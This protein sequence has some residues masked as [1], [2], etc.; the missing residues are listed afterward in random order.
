MY[1]GIPVVAKTWEG[2]TLVRT[3]ALPAA[4]VSLSGPVD[5]EMFHS[6]VAPRATVATTGGLASGDTAD[7]GFA[8]T[9]VGQY[10][11]V[12]VI[13]APSTSQTA[14]DA[15]T[16]A[17]NTLAGRAPTTTTDPA[18][19][20][21]PAEGEP[22]PPLEA[23]PSVYPD[24]VASINAPFCDKPTCSVSVS[25][26]NSG[27]GPGTAQVTT[28][29]IPGLGPTTETLGPIAPGGSANTSTY[30][31]PN[32]APTPAPGQTTTGSA[33]VLVQIYSQEIGGTKPDRYNSLVDK[34]GGPAKQPSLDRILAP[35]SQ[36]AKDVM[37]EAMNR[38]LDEEV[39]PDDT[40]GAAEE[41][42]QA[43]PS[44]GEYADTPLLQQLANAGDR[45]T[46]WASVAELLNGADPAALPALL[47]GLEAA[48]QALAG[49]LAPTVSLTYLPIETAAPD[50]VVVADYPDAEP[51]RCTSV[52]ALSGADFAAA[53]E[54]GAALG[55]E[56]A[57]DCAVEV[58][59]VAPQEAPT[60]PRTAGTTE[61]Q[62][63]LAPAVSTLCEGGDPG[64]ER[65][66]V[67]NDTGVR[68][69]PA[70]SVCAMARPL[71]EEQ[72]VERL[73]TLGLPEAVLRDLEAKRLVTLGTDGAIES[74]ERPSREDCK[75]AYTNGGAPPATASSPNHE[76]GP[77]AV[78]SA[79]R[80]CK[81]LPTGSKAASITLWDWPST[82]NP[83]APTGGGFSIY[84]RCHLVGNQLGGTGTDAA[85][86]VTCFWG[87]NQN[88]RIEIETPVK[89]RVQSGEQVFYLS[90][91]QYNGPDGEL[92][93]IRVVATG[94]K[95]F[96]QDSCF[97]NEME[98]AG[99]HLDMSC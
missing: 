89:Q 25:V 81:P 32:P 3:A 47:P 63:L 50:A 45:F 79:A 66:T 98:D 13:P 22:P 51:N 40:L 36:I 23:F 57:E 56:A 92:S 86:L 17:G 31:I 84:H 28:T 34:L 44:R 21:A 19:P 62:E 65:L 83:L 96:F 15:S 18:A 52:V 68:D 60:V 80:L 97:S 46:S 99:S 78:Y 74:I 82:T 42:V 1:Q 16:T 90:V 49:P 87:T 35:L 11:L 85:N 24:F 53:I 30:S 9:A 5:P 8:Q 67:V 59:V 37:V 75:S 58:R 91:P 7:R 77:K 72:V 61:L 48:A 33:E 10:G 6:T 41:A 2:W 94:D 71:T 29:V 69:W 27:T 14:T 76:D 93:G 38:M 64:F 39:T 55:G 70:T 73:N 20:S 12:E 43:E 26:S 4:I 88:M 95:G 54:R